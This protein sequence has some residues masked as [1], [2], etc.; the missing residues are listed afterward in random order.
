MGACFFCDEP[1][2]KVRITVTPVQRECI[3]LCRACK[4]R[5][6]EAVTA[7]REIFHKGGQTG[8]V[9][10]EEEGQSVLRP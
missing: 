9:A 7:V 2:Y 5:Y 3:Y 4:P 1:G 10:C 6:G 8:A